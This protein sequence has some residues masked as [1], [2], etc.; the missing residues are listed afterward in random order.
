MRKWPGFS[1]V[2]SAELE[3]RT[4]T[5]PASAEWKSAALPLSYLRMSA[6]VDMKC[7]AVPESVQ[8]VPVA[9]GW[10]G[11]TSVAQ[12]AKSSTS[13]EVEQWNGP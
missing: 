1:S 2:R 5:E 3:L 9:Y 11:S 4:R 13:T 6:P 8:P 7:R 12:Q 10:S